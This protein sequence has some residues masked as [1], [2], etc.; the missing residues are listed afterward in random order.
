MRLGC[1]H[2]GK[3]KNNAIHADNNDQGTTMPK[4]YVVNNDGKIVD[5]IE[6][7]SKKT[8]RQAYSQHIGC[9]FD[10]VLRPL[11]VNSQQWR[12]V[13]VYSGGHNHE[14]AQELSSYPMIRRLD[15]DDE[16]CYINQNSNKIKRLE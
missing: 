9:E 1:K 14:L 3:P 8:H 10:I 6:T 13:S 7:K 11:N 5:S 4:S 12:V 16:K 15:N 2:F